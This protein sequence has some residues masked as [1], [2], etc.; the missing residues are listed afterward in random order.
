M[1]A[2]DGTDAA[3]LHRSGRALCLSGGGYRAA[4]FHLGAMW[5]LQQAGWLPQV[6]LVSSVSGGSIVSAW[7]VRRYIDGRQPDEPFGDWCMRADFRSDL[8]EPFRAVVARDIRTL[9][10]LATLHRNWISPGARVARLQQAYARFLGDLTLHDLPATPRFVFCAT[11]LT[12]GV[13]FE[14]SR[15]R[16]GDYLAGY[17][18]RV[19]P[20]PLARAVAASSSFPPVFGPVAFPARAADFHR[21]RYRG[22]DAERLR[23]R[24]E[25]TDGGVYDNLGTEP[26]LRRYREVLVSDAGAPF[27][28]VPGRHYLRRLLRYTEVIGN[29]AV[30]LRRRLLTARLREDGMRGSYWNLGGARDPGRHGYSPTA[31]T[32]VA[33]IRTDLDRFDDA[34]FEALVNH[35]YFACENAL[36]R[37]LPEQMASASAADWPFPRRA[38]EAALRRAL[39][40]SHRR[41]RPSRWWSA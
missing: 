29:Q 3:V 17:L 15:E 36:Q 22:D 13:N 26:A 10:V 6:E 37:D 32:A 38:D 16:V 20:I 31:I 30:A 34:E 39:G 8:I 12:F 27:A 24:I 9:A 35:G 11:D 21:G 18:R 33:A 5:R 14:F 25:L 2:R 23:E 28:F 40:G 7:L 4:L 41:F 1:T 19:P